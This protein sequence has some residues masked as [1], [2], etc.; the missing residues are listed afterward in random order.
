MGQ[1]IGP[2]VHIMFFICSLYLSQSVKTSNGNWSARTI[3]YYRFQKNF[4]AKEYWIPRI[5]F[6]QEK[7][8]WSVFA[9]SER[10]VAVSYYTQL[11][12]NALCINMQGGKTS[13]IDAWRKERYLMGLWTR[14]FK[15]EIVL[16]ATVMLRSVHLM[17]RGPFKGGCLSSQIG[18]TSL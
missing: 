11:L 3:K 14:W 4:S 5:A 12:C 15:S 18:L 9:W 13:L 2:L 10:S 6:W 8:F 7:Q 17:N 1:L 16:M